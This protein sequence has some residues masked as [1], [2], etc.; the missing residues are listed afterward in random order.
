[1]TC[2]RTPFRIGRDTVISLSGAVLNSSI[3]NSYERRARSAMRTMTGSSL[4]RWRYPSDNYGLRAKLRPRFRGVAAISALFSSLLLAGCM[5]ISENSTSTHSQPSNKRSASGQIEISPSHLNFGNVS[6]GS[7]SSQR[8]TLTARTSSVA[9]SSAAWSGD[10]YSVTGITFPTKVP[11]GQ[12][13][14]F[15]V[16]F[17]P[18]VAGIASGRISFL[19]DASNSPVVQTLTGRGAQSSQHSVS[20]SW[21]PSTSQVLGYNIYRGAQSGGPYTRLNARPQ[22]G[23]SFADSNVQSGMTYF[24]VATAVG[25]DSAESPYSDEVM[26][27]IPK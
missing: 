11:V 27:A 9:V 12:S 24:Y 7:S 26:V 14:S 17:A 8:G 19:A 15:A 3:R 20:L 6:V 25:Y 23:T 1:M 5:G 22:S 4:E 21:N 18:Q 13:I 10:G 2:W 16:T